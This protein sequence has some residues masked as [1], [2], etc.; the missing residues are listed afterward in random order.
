MNCMKCGKDISGSGVFCESCLQVMAQYPIKPSAPV[1]LP[2]KKEA[3][4]VKKT[5]RKRAIPPEE[6]VAL[7]K[8]VIKR[9]RIALTVLAVA[10]ALVTGLLVYKYLQDMNAPD[11][12]VGIS[13]NYTI[14]TTQ[15]P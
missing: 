7:Q 3:P 9:L 1:H 11:P 4:V 10:F 2:R 8:R 13:R 12:T 15:Q 6:Q 5:P 14:D